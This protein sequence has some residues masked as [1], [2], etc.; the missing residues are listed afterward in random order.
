MANIWKTSLFSKDEK[1]STFMV[2]VIMPT[3]DLKVAE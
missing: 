1:L 3:K 2:S